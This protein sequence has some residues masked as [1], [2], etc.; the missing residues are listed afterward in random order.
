VKIS[1]MSCEKCGE[2]K[3]LG[4]MGMCQKVLI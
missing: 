1:V 4:T 3:C 2:G